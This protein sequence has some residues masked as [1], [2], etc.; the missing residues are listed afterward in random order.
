[1][2]A[3]MSRFSSASIV[4][5]QLACNVLQW[6]IPTHPVGVSTVTATRQRPERA[7]PPEQVLPG[8]LPHPLLMLLRGLENFAG[9][10]EPDHLGFVVP[11]DHGLE[12]FALEPFQGLD[13]VRPAIDEVTDGEQAVPPGFEVDRG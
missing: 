9:L 7:V 5:S 2:I 1:M 8:D 11:H 10:Q 12:A 3:S 4:A 13:G 6:T